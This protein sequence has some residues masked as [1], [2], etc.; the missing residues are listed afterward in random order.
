MEWIKVINKLP[1]NEGEYIVYGEGLIST[2]DFI[3]GKWYSDLYGEFVDQNKI[4]HWMP[5]PE[6][7][8]E[9]SQADSKPAN[10]AIFDVSNRRELLIAFL[11]WL[12]EEP[13]KETIEKI[14]DHYIK[15]N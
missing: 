11:T 1:E 9:G 10:C 5:L 3:E 14:I 7:P 4:T 8:S 2:L 15:S 13:Q 12:E 6:K